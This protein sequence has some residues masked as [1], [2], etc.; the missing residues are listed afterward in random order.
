MHGHSG[1]TVQKEGCRK[2]RR[3]V[4]TKYYGLLRNGVREGLYKVVL[5]GDCD[6]IVMVTW[7]QNGRMAGENYAYLQE[8]GHL[9][10]SSVV[11][12]DEVKKEE[13]LSGYDVVNGILDF[14]DGSRWEGD[15]VLDR[16]CG[17]GKKFSDTNSLIYEGME[18]NNQYE[19]SGI[20][21]ID[22]PYSSIPTYSGEWCHG[23]KH[24]FGKT[25]DLNGDVIREGMWLNDLPVDDHIQLTGE[26][27]MTEFS[28]RI[29][30]CS[31]ASDSYNLLSS[32]DL[33]KC[34]CLCLLQIGDRSCR[35]VDSFDLRGLRSLEVVII[36]SHS[37]SMVPSTW[38]AHRVANHNHREKSFLVRNCR[39]LS[40]LSIGLN[41]FSDFSS[42]SVSGWFLFWFSFQSVPRWS[43]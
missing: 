6:P 43:N 13:T 22:E 15:F 35:H 42:F 38:E 14:P 3:V 40:S 17:Q 5:S 11:E 28:C 26:V 29:E 34:E 18:V 23:K 39:M 1:K 10:Y 31:I 33:S 24:G 4:H 20:S 30:S 21:F 41:S 9:L 32:L 19:G 25:F 36:G 27:E 16:S 37:F 12:N 2:R 8:S 7:F